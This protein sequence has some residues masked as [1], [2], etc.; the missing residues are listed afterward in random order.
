MSMPYDFIKNRIFPL[1]IPLAWRQLTSER[2][3][4]CAALAGVAFGVLLMMFELGLYSSLLEKVVRPLRLLTGEVVITSLNRDNFYIA[5]LFTERRLYQALASSDVEGV[6]PVYLEMTTLKHPLT[7][8][9]AQLCAFGVDPARPALVI[10]DLEHKIDILKQD[11][12]VLFDSLA[13]ARF[14]PIRQM[15]QR[16]GEVETLLGGHRVRVK[17]FCPMGQTFLADTNVLMGERAFLRV[18]EGRPPGMINYGVV[19]LKPGVNPAQAAARLSRILPEDVRVLTKEALISEEQAYWTRRTPIGFVFSSGAL[20]AMIVGSVIAYQILYSDVNDHMKEYAT[21]RAVGIADS[22]LL[23][24]VLEQAAILSV[25]GFIPGAAMTSFL[26]YITRVNADMPV[27]F[28]VER[29]LF[30]LFLNFF[31]CI[32]AGILATRKLRLLN[33]ADI[34]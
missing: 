4:F 3:R 26:Y 18:F 30:V 9:S 15:V 32:A 21:L 25:L 12:Y 23:R 5:N 20:L 14:G 2:K 22:F 34:F 16:R 10:P 17:G 31:T 28:T 1:G 8:V 7:G 19:M 11:E 27:T 29:T 6:A 24:L 13:P 33:P